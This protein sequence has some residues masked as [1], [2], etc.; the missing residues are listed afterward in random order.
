MNLDA[1]AEDMKDAGL[2]ALQTYGR[3]DVLV[4]GAWYSIKSPVEEMPEAD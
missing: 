2:S 3:M 4:N 1:S